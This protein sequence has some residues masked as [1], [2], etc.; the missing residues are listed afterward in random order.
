MAPRYDV[1]DESDDRYRTAEERDALTEPGREIDV[2]DRAA[3]G[4]ELFGQVVATLCGG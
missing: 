4:A 2:G 3:R 1:R